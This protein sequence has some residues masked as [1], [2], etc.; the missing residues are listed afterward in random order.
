[1]SAQRRVQNIMDVP[2]SVASYSPEQMEQQGIR[3]I[4]DIARL[5]PSLK[6]SRTSGVSGNNASDISIRGIASDVGSATTAIYIDDTPIQIRSIGYFGGNTYPLVF[7]LERIEVLRGPQGTLFGAGA[8]GGA[9]RFLTPAA[10]FRGIRACTRAAKS[11]RS[12][13]ATRRTSWASPAARRSAKRVALR[14]GVWYR[15]DG[16]YIDRYN[17]TFTTR[18]E[19]DINDVDNYSGKIALGWRPTEALTVTPSFYYQKV[20]SDGRPQYWQA[21]SDLDDEDYVTGIYNEEPSYGPIQSAGDQGRVRLRRHRSHLQHVLLP[22]RTLAGPGLRHVPQHAA[23]RQPIR[24]LRQQGCIERG[25]FPDARA[26]QLRAGSAAAVGAPRA[27]RRLEHGRVLFTRRPGLDE[28]LRLRVHSR[29]ALE[30]RSSSILAVTTSMTPSKPR[31]SNT[32]RSRAST[33]KRRRASRQRWGS[34]SRATSSSSAK[35]A[36]AR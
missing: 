18:L 32:P 21:Q 9:V 26:A 28:P 1:M 10:G 2:L 6:F 25:R 20:E 16:G 24:H 36:T 5:T 31:T 35:R 13:T 7:D 33:S 15:H 29:R 14:G 12:A 19:K 22:S 17:P 30:R 34:V 3:A 11:P 8:E 23:I 4:D 27:A